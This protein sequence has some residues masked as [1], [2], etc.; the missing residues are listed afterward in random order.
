M[1]VT[2]LKI[3]VEIAFFPLLI[4]SRQKLTSTS[5]EFDFVSLIF[6]AMMTPKIL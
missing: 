1:K 5:S 2:V 4:K 6:T 3:F